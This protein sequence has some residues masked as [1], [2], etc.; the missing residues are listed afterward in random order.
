[1][2][3]KQYS[4]TVTSGLLGSAR[5]RRDRSRARPRTDPYPQRRRAHDGIAVIIAGVVSFFVELVF[6]LWFYNGFSFRGSRSSDDRAAAAP[7]WQ[8]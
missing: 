5:R 4:I 8:S 2:N 6:R 7:A 1:M 3:D